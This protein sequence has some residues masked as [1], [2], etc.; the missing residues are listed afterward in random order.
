MRSGHAPDHATATGAF[1]RRRLPLG[2]QTFREIR[3]SGCY[4]VDKTPFVARMLDEGK[5]YFLSRPRRFGKSLLLDTV[6]ELFEGNEPL[7]RGLAVHDAW[8]WSAPHP[9]VRLSFGSGDFTRAGE[10][11]DRTMEQLAAAER[12][13]GVGGE[14]TTAAGRFAHLVETLHERD[15]RRVVVLVDE[16]DKPVLD[17]LDDPGVA[18]ANRD[19]L[20]GLYAT[21]ED[22]DAHVRFTLFTGVSRFSKVNLFSGLNN[23]T[24]IT[25]D[26][27]FSAICGYTEHDLDTVFA[28]ELHGLDRDAIRAW[29]D[30]YNWLGTENVYNPYD[31]LLLFRRRQFRPWW[32]ETGTPAFLVDTLAREGPGTFALEGA[33]GNEELLSSF[34]VGAV[35]PLALLFQSGYLTLRGTV[36]R[37]GRLLYRLDYPNREVRQCLN[38]RLLAH[39][40]HDPLR[41]EA[42]SSQLYEAVTGAD[43]EAMRAA[44]D[45]LFSGIPYQWHVNNPMGRYEGYYASV[46]YASFVALGLDVRVEDS[47]SAGRLDMAVVV[48]GHVHVLELK[49]RERATAGAALAQL[50]EKGYAEKYRA[51]GRSLHLVA[52]ELDA[53]RRSI[54][55]FD[56]ASA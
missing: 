8:A 32:F 44:L 37:A 31:V 39:A 35:A 4:Y 5:H 29:Y 17:T 16:Y 26:A 48:S 34:D 50:R 45:A 27:E 30:G 51:P 6:K 22:C 23:L 42:H 36:E 25:V 43:F 10:A 13:E 53:E 12:R 24:D 52:V 40:M 49:V 33:T 3:E 15:G 54:A 47:T 11:L 18:R 21:V 38:E 14:G 2:I 55:A 28:P 9:V 1:A 41:R 46:F 20:R 7:F 19:F 56:V